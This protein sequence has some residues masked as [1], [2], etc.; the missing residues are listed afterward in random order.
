MS[1]L[2]NDFIVTGRIPIEA[3]NQIA[4]KIQELE[5]IIKKLTSGL[6]HII[7]ESNAYVLE[8]NGYKHADVHNKYKRMAQRTLRLGK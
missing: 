4:F 8:K 2:N 5:M 6:N 3:Y 7:A 1:E